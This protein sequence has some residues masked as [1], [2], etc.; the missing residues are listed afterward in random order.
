MDF[1]NGNPQHNQHN[2]PRPGQPARRPVFSDFA[3]RPQSKPP[4]APPRPASSPLSIAP[5]KPV[6]TEPGRPETDTLTPVDLA[7]PTAATPAAKEKETKAPHPTAHSGL[8]GL[9]LFVVL[10]ALALSPLLPG[11]VFEEFP[12]NSQSISTG[13]QSIGCISDLA[14]VRT[15]TATD[16]K[17]GFPVVYRYATTSTLHATCQ[18]QDKTAT[19]GRTSQFNPLGGLINIFAAVVIAFIVAKVWRKLLSPKHH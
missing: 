14:N 5:K 9:V 12:G 16:Y 2:R 11:K 7:E 17:W 15:T 19:G 10:A 13:E 18:G 8:V 1:T 4:L 3:P 6:T